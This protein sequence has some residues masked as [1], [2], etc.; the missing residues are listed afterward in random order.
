[1]A[2]QIDARVETAAW[3]PR[4]GRGCADGPCRVAQARTAE[5]RVAIDGLRAEGA[6]PEKASLRQVAA[7]T[8][9]RG[10]RASQGGIR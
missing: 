8:E 5:M 6:I 7:T 9:A 1:M 3:H 10:V 4:R 2:T